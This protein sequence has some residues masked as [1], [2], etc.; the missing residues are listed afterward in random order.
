LIGRNRLIEGA[1][2]LIDDESI[3]RIFEGTDV[4]TQVSAVYDL[5]GLSLY[6]G[7]IDVHIHGAFGVDT[8]GASG[9]DL[10]RM[11]VYLAS[12]GVTSWLP[13]LVPGAVEEYEHLVLSIDELMSR[14]ETNAARAV[15]VHYEGPFVNESQCGALHTSHFRKFSSLA[16]LDDLPV[17]GHP[18][19]IRMMTVAPEIQ[20][21]IELVR[22]LR[23]R[24][25]VVSI[26]HTRASVEVLN[27][28]GDAGARHMTHFMNAMSPVNHRS[29]GPIGWGLMNDDV[30][31]DII[32]DGIHL[33]ELIL[34]LIVRAKTA[35]RILLISDA[36]LPAGLG[37]GE[38]R[39]WGDTIT[40][41]DRRTSNEKG[42]IAGSVISMR[43]AVKKMRSLGFSP[44]DVALMASTNPA[45]LL[46]IDGECGSIEE[47]KRADLVA[48]DDDG[49]VR[50]TIIGGRIAYDP[51]GRT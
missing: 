51:D 26:G 8:M 36:V 14:D 18:K 45:R 44:V 4:P 3:A 48:I 46:S 40:V 7:F 1:S 33:D 29:P 17:P 19:A 50:L 13:T 49:R 2:V 5:D 31:C 34:K 23:A 28:A 11:G 22:S 30:T 6:P 20:G 43:D 24:G 15:G 10:Y 47:G 27:Q 21:G 16:D 41:L 12:Q 9:D 38:F 35:N 39:V 25:W 32:A 37:D 42:S